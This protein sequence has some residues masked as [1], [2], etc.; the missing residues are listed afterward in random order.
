MTLGSWFSSL[1]HGRRPQPQTGASRGRSHAFH[2]SASFEALEDRFLLSSV[3]FSTGSETVDESSGTFSIPVTLSSPPAGMPTIST[4]VPGINDPYG[5]AFDA[6]GD[7][8][9][10]NYLGNSVKKVTPAGV[11]ST[12]ASGLIDQQ[13]SCDPETRQDRR[14]SVSMAR[15]VRAAILFTKDRL[16]SSQA[17]P[18]CTPAGMPPLRAKPPGP[19]SGTSTGRPRQTDR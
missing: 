17:I 3:S 1:Q 10:A 13:L 15:A 19:G 16:R 8:Y 9:V 12:F 5:L 2:R 11:V 14:I 4:F 6:A 7:L 18:R